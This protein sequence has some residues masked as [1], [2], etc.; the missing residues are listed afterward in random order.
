MSINIDEYLTKLQSGEVSTSSVSDLRNE[1]LQ[2]KSYGRRISFLKKDRNTKSRILLFKSLAIP[3][4][5]FTCVE[6]VNYNAGRKFRTEKS[7]TTT[8]LALKRFY[9]QNEEAKQ[10]FLVK[11]K[12]TEW[13]TSNLSVITEQDRKVFAKF[14]VSNIFTI[15]QIHINNKAVTGKDNG[16]DFKVDIKRDE[17]GNIIEKW[18]DSEGK[19]CTLPNFVKTAV[20]LGNFFSAAYLQEY[21]D[22]E[23]SEG[24]NKTDDDKSKK[25]LSIMSQSPIQEDRPRNTILGM[26]LPLAAKGLDLDYEA[27]KKWEEKDFIKALVQVSYTKPIRT[28]I[29]GLQADYSHKDTFADFYEVDM[30]VPDIEEPKQRGQDTVYNYVDFPVKDV[31]GLFSKIINALDSLENLDKIMLAS[32]YV[33]PL[34]SDVIEALARN[35]KDT[36]DL[37]KLSLTDGTVNRFGDIISLV[38]GDKAD[39]ILVDA[40]MGELP[41]ETVTQEDRDL[42]KA[43]IMSALSEDDELEEVDLSV[44]E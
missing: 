3:F 31:D 42:A 25:R 14:F 27:I 22:W 38:W 4:N 8:L 19:V 15:N 23:L 43:A 24:A 29:E 30:I 36:C 34:T 13:D 10:A 21:K 41:E 33:D 20:S 5:P 39:S 9:H 28:K 12:E 44:G 32:S 11:A 37:Q 26:K 16:A 7:V 40:S 2:K 1:D 6:D 18:E 35:L 17:V